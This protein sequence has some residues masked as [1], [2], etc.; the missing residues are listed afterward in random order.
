MARRTDRQLKRLGAVCLLVLAV[1]MAASFNL[2]KFPGFRGTHYHAQFKDASGLKVGDIVEIAGI[3][4]GRVD[5]LTIAGDHIDVDFD[6]HGTKLPTATCRT[7]G[8]R[9]IRRVASS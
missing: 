7:P 9:A 1:A 3:R 6:I 2:Q 4:V 8:S 5:K